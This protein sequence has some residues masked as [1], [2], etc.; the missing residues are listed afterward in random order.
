MTVHPSEKPLPLEKM[1]A[2]VGGYI[3]TMFRV[4]SPFRKHITLSGYVNEE[5][6]IIGLP[7]V[8]AVVDEYGYRPFAGSMVIVAENDRTGNQSVMTQEEVDFLMQNLRQGRVF[9]MREKVNA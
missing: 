4:N 2:V 8:G 7:I 5:G 6:L 1:Q 3:E 9:D